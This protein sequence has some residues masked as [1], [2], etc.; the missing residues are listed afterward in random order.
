MQVVLQRPLE[1]VQCELRFQFLE[2][3]GWA[4]GKGASVGWT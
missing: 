1:I 2:N 3:T 4:K